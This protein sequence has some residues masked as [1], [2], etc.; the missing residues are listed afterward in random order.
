MALLIKRQERGQRR[1]E[2]KVA[3]EIERAA[4][5]RRLEGCAMAMSVRFW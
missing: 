2:S 1:V 5:A 3:V 4:R